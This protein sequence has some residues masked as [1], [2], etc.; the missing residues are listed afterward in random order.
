MAKVSQKSE[1]RAS[2]TILG[3]SPFVASLVFVF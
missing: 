3:A 2:V 1:E